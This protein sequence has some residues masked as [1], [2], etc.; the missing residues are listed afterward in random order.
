MG[1]LCEETIL[2]LTVQELGNQRTDVGVF[3]PTQYFDSRSLP[4]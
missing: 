3:H 1:D 2:K 4:R